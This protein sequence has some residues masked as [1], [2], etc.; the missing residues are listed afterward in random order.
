MSWNLLNT[1]TQSITFLIDIN[2]V[3]FL[4]QSHSTYLQKTI[5]SY[6]VKKQ[7]DS[8]T[9][10]SK[11]FS[12]KEVN[13]FNWEHSSQ[14]LQGQSTTFTPKTSM[15]FTSRLFLAV[16]K[17]TLQTNLDIAKFTLI[18][19]FINKHLINRKFCLFTKCKV[20]KAFIFWIASRINR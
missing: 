4:N 8:L 7:I 20:F 12:I 14:I 9:L 6:T 16:K 3:H 19:T 10:N 5:K 11:S 1:N 13:S 2:L 17:Q 18:K 15:K